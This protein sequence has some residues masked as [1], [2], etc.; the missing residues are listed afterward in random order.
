MA[1]GSSKPIQDVHVGDQVTNKDPDTGQ[2]QTHAVVATHITDDDH[3]FVDL[4]VQTPSGISTITVTAHHLFWDATTHS[5]TQADTLHVGD[6]LDTAGHGIA[7]VVANHP[8]TGSIRTYNLTVDH[9][10]TFFVAGGGLSVLVHN[11]P[12]GVDASG[13]PCSCPSPRPA[14]W[15]V[16]AIDHPDSAI[17]AAEQGGDGMM[18]TL[19]RAGASARREANLRGEPT[20]PNMD[21]DEFPPATFKEGR[22][23]HIKLIDAKDNRG[24]GSTIRHQLADIPNGG[25][26]M[27]G[28]LNLDYILGLEDN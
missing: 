17:H 28:I 12:G 5:W 27:I 14:T 10:H 19:D 11:C 23:A 13:A 21:R 15:V 9:L 16:D 25:R 8:Y 20:A 24:S 2:V 26:V 1:D 7:T 6:Q 3:D 18:V 4:T 22:G